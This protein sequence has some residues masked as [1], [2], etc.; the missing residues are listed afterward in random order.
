MY[1]LATHLRA[2]SL[3]VL[4]LLATPA[5]SQST[6]SSKHLVF[7]KGNVSIT[8]NG[9][10][11]IPSFSLG[12]PALVS[13]FSVSGPRRFSFEPEFRYSLEGKPWS[14][15]FI[16]RYKLIKRE[17]FQLALG[18]HLPTLAFVS[19]PVIKNGVEQE[20]IQARRFFPVTELIPQYVFSK[21][22]SLGMY[23]LYG[24]GVE[25]ELTRH[26]H[27]VSLRVGFNHI[28]LSKRYFLRFHPQV[29]YLKL[30]DHDGFYTTGILTLARQNFPLSVSTLV[31]KKLQSDIA[32]KDFD[33][34]VSLVYSFG[35]NYAGQ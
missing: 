5:F 15:I 30:D 33:W 19:G 26:T 20:A 13:T 25:K 14:F 27:F 17:K 2:T 21:N 8:N 12:K 35:R 32:G 31:N 4:L 9:F 1:L 6:D 10:S 22:I 11:L 29:Y 24:R 34:N 16:W 23:Y 18:T 7:F 3:F 28:P